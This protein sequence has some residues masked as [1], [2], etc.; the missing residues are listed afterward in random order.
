[1]RSNSH[2][3]LFILSCIL[4]LHFTSQLFS[5]ATRLPKGIEASGSVEAGS[6][7]EKSSTLRRFFPWLKRKPTEALS[8]STLWK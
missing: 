3:F 5:K 6:P 2:S 4:Q 7:K 1:M 8:G